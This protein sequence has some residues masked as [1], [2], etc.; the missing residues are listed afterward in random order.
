M[1]TP[2]SPELSVIPERLA[3]GRASSTRPLV[4]SFLFYFLGFISSSSPAAILAEITDYILCWG[5]KKATAGS[6]GVSGITCVMLRYWLRLP[7]GPSRGGGRG[8][9]PPPRRLRLRTAVQPGRRRQTYLHFFFKL[10]LAHFFL[11]YGFYFVALKTQTRPS[12]MLFFCLHR[13][14]VTLSVTPILNS[15]SH[16]AHV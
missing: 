14:S 4:L 11:P 12:S 6:A 2:C 7:R 16:H 13:N 5:D 10:L 1:K 15:V 8:G 3:S 9:S